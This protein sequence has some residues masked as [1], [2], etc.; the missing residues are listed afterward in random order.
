M[1]KALSRVE[2]V[3]G[4]ASDVKHNAGRAD[5]AEDSDYVQHRLDQAAVWK[6]SSA[7]PIRHREQAAL[8]AHKYTQRATRR[9]RFQAVNANSQPWSTKVNRVTPE[10]RASPLTIPIEFPY[11]L[12]HTH[13]DDRSQPNRLHT[14]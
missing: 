3:L 5:A 12:S 14:T 1:Q 2:F 11:G 4:A 10:T 6:D 7:H 9:L 8:T 13:M